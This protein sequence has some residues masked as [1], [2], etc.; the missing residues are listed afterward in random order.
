ML[1][2]DAF[3]YHCSKP[4]VARIIIANSRNGNLAAT[5]MALALI[6]DNFATELT[7]GLLEE[8]L[9]VRTTNA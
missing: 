6:R 4:K 5:T 7:I 8:L 1:E 2:D 3:I 9:T